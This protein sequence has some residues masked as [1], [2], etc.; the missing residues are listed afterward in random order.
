MSWEDELSEI[1]RNHA[2]PIQYGLKRVAMA[3]WLKGLPD[4]TEILCLALVEDSTCP[5]KWKVLAAQHSADLNAILMAKIY[6]ST[7]T[8]PIVE[9]LQI[10]RDLLMR[11]PFG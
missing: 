10:L 11:S 3:E 6:L 5:E 7:K 9:N 1:A 8:N 2:A 4:K